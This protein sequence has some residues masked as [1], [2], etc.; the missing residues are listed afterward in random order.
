M[1]PNSSHI[2]SDII[3]PEV[4]V[5]AYKQGLFPMAEGVNGPIYWH[6]P[7]PRAI[8]PLDKLKIHKTVRQTI[9]R[10]NLEFKIDT[11][12]EEVVERCA[13][14]EECWIN[15]VIYSSFV[16]LHNFGYAHSVEAYKGKEL[17]G[18]LY[19]VSIGGAFFGESMFTEI[20]NASKAAFFY[21]GYHLLQR[22]FILLDSQYINPHTELLGAVDIPRS[23][24]MKILKAAVKMPVTFS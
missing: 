3:P 22:G 16:N 19:G 24:Y 15:E 23:V 13:N 8:I 4:L 6:S 7:D 1:K 14:R 11:N 9:R 2:I 5:M 21:L 18:G 20:T 17:V 12:F 10:E